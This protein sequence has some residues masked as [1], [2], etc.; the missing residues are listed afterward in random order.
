MKNAGELLDRLRQDVHKNFAMIKAGSFLMGSDDQSYGSSATEIILDEFKIT[1]CPITNLQYAI[2]LN[3]FGIENVRDGTYL[4]MNSFNK[5]IR[6]KNQNGT[7]VVQ[8][9][10][11]THP[12]THV[13]WLGACAFS[14]AVG[15]RLPTEAE[16][17]KAA[18]GGLAG[19]LFPWGD[20]APTPTLANFGENV[21][22]TAKV[23]SY[24]P[25]GYGLYDMAGNVWEWTMDWYK[26]MYHNAAECRNPIGPADGVD[27]V[28]RGGGWAYP[29]SDL[30]CYSRG[31]S[32]IRLG[33]TNVG[34]RLVK[35]LK[36]NNAAPCC[37]KDLRRELER[38]K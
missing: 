12:V 23:G 15:A 8:D 19:K 34:F 32:W 36:Q 27:K 29:G 26:P 7:Y 33:G 28:I 6:I 30:R 5:S 25:N 16:W 2:F 14:L 10:F 31:R 4:F 18:R 13:N 17:E 1:R 38:F 11:E 9:G 20:N 37:I 21:G 24:P 22:M 3:A 35:D